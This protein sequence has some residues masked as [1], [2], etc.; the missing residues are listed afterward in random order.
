MDLTGEKQFE[1]LDWLTQTIEPFEWEGTSI[2]AAFPDKLELSLELVIKTYIKGH[3][4]T[5]ILLTMLASNYGID[6]KALKDNMYYLDTCFNVE[7]TDNIRI[8]LEE[9]YMSGVVTLVKK[10][11]E[12]TDQEILEILVSKMR[13][14]IHVNSYASLNRINE[15]VELLGLNNKIKRSISVRN[16][17]RAI[18]N[19]MVEKVAN[20]EWKIKDVKLAQSIADS[21]SRY[22]EKGNIKDLDK[23]VRFKM[24]THSGLPIYKVEIK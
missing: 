12:F 24:M 21:V 3:G 16:K 8:D 9:N 6:D 15:I 23:F 4:Y 1:K 10:K 18:K 17:I 7:A 22:I 19:Y 5:S 13:D 11:K 14:H 20:G 2:L